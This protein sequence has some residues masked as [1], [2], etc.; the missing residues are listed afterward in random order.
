MYAPV[1]TRFATY[2]VKLDGRCLDYCGRILSLPHVQERIEAAQ[3]E[4][5]ALEEL[6]VEFVELNTGNV[7]PK[8]SQS[9]LSNTSPNSIS[10]VYPRNSVR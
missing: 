6:D 3:A 1:Y 7:P 8:A 4:P 9:S 2:D 5:E 10:K